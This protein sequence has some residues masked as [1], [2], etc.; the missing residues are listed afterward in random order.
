MTAPVADLTARPATADDLSALRLLWL[1][2]E[3]CL[4]TIGGS[5]AQP[6][7]ADPAKFEG[8][9]D[10]AFGAQPLCTVLPAERWPVGPRH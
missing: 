8:F 7:T 1:A 4:D 2:F 6:A 5:I 10:L 3:A 9:A